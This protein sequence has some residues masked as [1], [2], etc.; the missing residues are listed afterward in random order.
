MFSTL[1]LHRLGRKIQRRGRKFPKFQ[2]ANVRDLWFEE[3]LEGGWRVGYRLVRQGTRIVVGEVRV[4]PDEEETFLRPGRWSGEIDGVTATVPD[5][6]ITGRLLRKLKGTG[7]L[8]FAQKQADAIR[9]WF[10]EFFETE[11]KVNDAEK[12][13]GGRPALD[14]LH[15]VRLAQDYINAIDK[16]SRTPIADVAREH[17]LPESTM[18]DRIHIARHKRKLFTAVGWGRP[19]GAL[20]PKGKAIL[21]TGRKRGNGTKK[22]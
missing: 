5:G 1:E 17:G 12:R 2:K 10:P 18:R 11:Q 6:G 4:F 9:A 16:G 13:R 22:K 20:T 21:G 3:P 14:D 7:H 15:Y 8:K 19:G